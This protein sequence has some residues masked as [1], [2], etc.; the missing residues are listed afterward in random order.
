MTWKWQESGIWCGKRWEQICEGRNYVNE[1]SI[2]TKLKNKRSS[3]SKY[4][5]D[6]QDSLTEETFL[7]T[8][9]K[10]VSWDLLIR[11]TRKTHRCLSKPQMIIRLYFLTTH[12]NGHTW[13]FQTNNQEK[14][15][16]HIWGKTVAQ[17]EST[18][19]QSQLFSLLWC[20]SWTVNF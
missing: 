4:Q 16:I 11:S 5:R 20:P 6:E 2:N 12:T 8:L 19:H 14:K 17:R 15:R 1:K 18:T 9:C 3:H 10:L 7:V 13:S